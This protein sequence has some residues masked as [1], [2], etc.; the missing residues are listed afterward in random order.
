MPAS[1]RTLLRD[2]KSGQKSAYVQAVEQH[3]ERIY[4]FLYRLAQNTSLA[5]D[6]TQDTF[7]AAWR[8]LDKFEGRS[9]VGTWLHKIALNVYREHVR[10]DHPMLWSIDDDET[11]SSPD[12]AP[13]LIERIG[14]EE[15][16]EKV[17]QAVSRLPE[18]Y[19]EVVILHCYQGLK[20]RE[21]ADLLGMPMGT[22]QHRLHVAMEKLRAQLREEVEDH[23]TTG[24]QH[25]PKL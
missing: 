8:S 21:I 22:M 6:L 19:R 3:Y 20:Y 13:E 7:A 23:E 10:R 15:L 16:Q 25:A 1:D 4:A 9:S 2:L 12:P 14:A 18:I 24:V 5:E 11:V 17:E